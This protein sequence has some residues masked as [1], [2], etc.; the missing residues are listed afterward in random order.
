MLSAAVLNGQVAMERLLQ[1]LSARSNV[2]TAGRQLRGCAGVPAMAWRLGVVGS[3]FYSQLQRHRWRRYSDCNRRLA[4]R[5]RFSSDDAD[6]PVRG[7]IGSV[8]N[9]YKRRFVFTNDVLLVESNRSVPTAHTAADSCLQ[10]QIV[11]GRHRLL[12]R[13]CRSERCVSLLQ[14]GG[15]LLSELHVKR[16]LA[17]ESRGC[18]FQARLRPVGLHV[19]MD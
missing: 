9:V 13:G 1:H 14:Q 3:V 19:L 4:S 12:H 18:L 7:P 5:W 2:G 17:A 11:F 16:C 6:D 10:R 15:R 8:S